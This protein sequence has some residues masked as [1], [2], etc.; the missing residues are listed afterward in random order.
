M[1][2]LAPGGTAAS[3]GEARKHLDTVDPAS[4]GM[5]ASFARAVIDE[6]YGD[7]RSAADAYLATLGRAATSPDED[8]PLI[9]WYAARHLSSLRASLT[10][11]FA[12]DRGALDALLAHPG[13][14]GWRAVADLE[15]WRAIEVHESAERTGEAYEDEVVRRMGCARNVRLA[16][17]FGHGVEADRDRKFDAEGPEPWPRAWAPDPIR[18]SVPHILSTTQKTCLAVAD[19]Q[20]QD[21]T[22]YAE[23]FFVSRGERELVVAVQGAS[24]VWIDGVK[25]LSRGVDQW[26]SW[27]RFGAHVAV[28]DGRHRIVARTLTPAASVRLLN[29]DGTSAGL[30]TGAAPGAIYGVSPPRIL[31]DPN[32]LEGIVQRSAKGEAPLAEMPVRAA[33]AASAAHTD[34]MDDVASTLMGP[35]A[36]APDAAGLALQLASTFAGTD[37]I[38]SEDARVSRARALRERALGRDPRIWRARLT[39][40]LDSAEQHGPAE[41]IEPMRRLADEVPGEP[42][43]LEDLAQLYGRLGWTGDQ[44]RALASLAQRFPDDVSALHAYLELLDDD[45][46]AAEADAV[47][48]RIA[49]LDPDAE[50]VLDRAIARHDYTAALA[51]LQR[52]KVRRPDRAEIVSRMADVLARS[53]D[54]RAAA[55][56][57]SKTLA[58]HPLDVQARFRLADRASAAGD[59]SALRRALA[60]ALQAGAN[61]DDLRA[62]I[63]LV[64][65]ATDLEPYRAD[66]LETIREFQRWEAGGHHM[67]GTA[68]RVL[69]YAAIWVHEDGSSE[70]LEHEIQKVQSQEAIAAESETEPPAGLVLHLRVIKP[71]GRIFEPEPIAGKVTLTMPHMEVGDF[72]EMEHVT[73]Q[74]GDGAKGR[75]Y[76]SPH[77]FFREADKG[78]WRSEF[79]V[80]TPADRQLEI[81]TRGNVPAPTE[82]TVGRFVERRWRVDQSPPA[83]TEPQ[84]PPI[85]EFLPSVRLG[86]GVTLGA[87]LERIVDLVVD[88]TP[89]D[90]R[91]RRLALGIVQGVRESAT[92]DRARLLYRW[93]LDHVQEGKETDGRRVITGNTGSRQSAFR[94]LLRLLGIESELALAKDGLAAPPL[95]K[96]SEV[97]QYGGLIVRLAT[98]HGPRWLTVRDKFAPYGYV[99]A[100]LREQSAIRIVPGT[101]AEIVHAPG[102][103]DGVRYEGRA[104]VRSDGSAAMDMT[105]TFAG[106]RAIVWRN[107]LDRIPEAKLYDF[108]E[109]ELI[110]PAL[111]GGHVRE[112]HLDGADAR[113]R[114]LSVKLR[115]EVPELAK[116]TPSG[117]SLRPPFVPALS[118]LAALPER[119]TPLLRRAAWRAEV[120]MQ[121][122]LPETI[123]VPA[124][125]PRGEA[126]EGAASVVVSDAI[127]G[128]TIAFDRVV[129]LP[130]G[131][132]APGEE[133]ALWQKFIREADTL[134][135]RNVLLAP[136]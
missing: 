58:K 94:Y 115:V 49:K 35:F 62:A 77:W 85:T 72:L 45:G 76:Q 48:A 65:G 106:E 114:A 105:V 8:A 70:M 38:L 78:Y 87:T 80:A 130:A 118:Q 79:V 125:M 64:E 36:E 61:T 134:L 53:G 25:V 21:G 14:I 7:P 66:G 28:G 32:P 19:E 96:M 119:H 73:R 116:P 41:D 31:A 1:E 9:G 11:L 109:R 104:E 103:A 82:K 63:D 117:L 110:A 54:P 131:R 18:R 3:A 102:M 34:Q 50:V 33:I 10:D 22:F 23:A 2:M 37:P 133:Y 92:D 74:G 98:E 26:G 93:A 6:T 29:P 89:L 47:A 13:H 75:Q 113:D 129:D 4:R 88:R 120:H 111:D 56:E 97:E 124:S 108:V 86:W 60:A 84:S 81:E 136:P 100:E 71:D 30:E 112:I 16:G 20:V 59:A 42:E 107:A 17:P 5:M 24:V 57:L 122:V 67:E 44:M 68:A 40:L 55:E 69:D 128:H 27:Q 95:G 126:R 46:A 15:D 101:P 12:R 51:E 52:L 132:V 99:P 121:V 39:A 90:P 123:R 43:I 127:S 91:L 83:E 135:S